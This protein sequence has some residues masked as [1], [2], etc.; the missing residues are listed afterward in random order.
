MK[1]IKKQMSTKDTK[2][3]ETVLAGKLHSGCSQ[4]NKK[5]AW[6]YKI[7]KLVAIK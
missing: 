5:L 6:L 4:R 1:S 2:K 7:I 3:H